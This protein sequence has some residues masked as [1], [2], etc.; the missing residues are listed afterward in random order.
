MLGARFVISSHSFL[1]RPYE[2]YACEAPA[3]LLL[4][5]LVQQRIREPELPYPRV[6][7]HLFARLLE[8]LFDS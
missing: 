6:L 7:D 5:L 1:R 3:L 2:R 4:L 8:A